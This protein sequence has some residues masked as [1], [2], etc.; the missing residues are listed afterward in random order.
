MKL[1]SAKFWLRI[2]RAFHA[3]G[4]WLWFKYRTSLTW[5]VYLTALV[6]MNVDN[7]L[8]GTP[9]AHNFSFY[10]MACF[11]IAA[12]RMIFIE[13]PRYKRR[14]K[15]RMAELD[16]HRARL[17]WW[18]KE[19]L[20]LKELAETDSRNLSD[21]ALGGQRWEQYELAAVRFRM[22]V[23]AFQETCDRHE[24][25]IEKLIGHKL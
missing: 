1:P 5:R 12:G 18:Q 21:I 23:D 13:Q 2:A 9:L 25:E 17:D 24:K 10:A 4:R 7:L 8:I 20:R 11:M 22:E 19:C 3:F 14:H 16:S 15:E 6:A